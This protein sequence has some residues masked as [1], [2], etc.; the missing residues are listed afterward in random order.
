MAL[1][2]VGSL[3][4]GLLGDAFGLRVAIA[5]GAAI[6]LIITLLLGVVYPPLRRASV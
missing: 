6:L 1:M 2:L 4:M 5:S 3:P